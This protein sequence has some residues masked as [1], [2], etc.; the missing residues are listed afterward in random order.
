MAVQLVETLPGATFGA[1]SDP[2]DC[3][4]EARQMLQSILLIQAK[5]R[6]A[7]F[8]LMKWNLICCWDAHNIK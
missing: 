1:D 3:M 5:F 7:V 6:P 4:T 2:V 8:K